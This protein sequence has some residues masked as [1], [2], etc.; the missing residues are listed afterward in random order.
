[1]GGPVLSLQ[2][3][4]SPLQLSLSPPLILLPMPPQP[5]TPPCGCLTHTG[6]P[7]KHTGLEQEGKESTF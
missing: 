3:F 2:A 7:H 5:P 1:M 4:L 6:T